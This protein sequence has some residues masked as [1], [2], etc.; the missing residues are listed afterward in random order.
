MVPGYFL[1]QPSIEWLQ[2]LSCPAGA[3]FYYMTPMGLFFTQLKLGL[4]YGLAF[5]SPVLAS[6]IWGFVAPAL[7][8]KE[9]IFMGVFSLCSCLLFFIG[10]CF[11][12]C[13]IFPLLMKFSYS[14][15]SA[16][17]APMLQ[18][19]SIIELAT[20]LMLGF[21]LMF[22]LPLIVI[23]LVYTDL[24]GIQRI[25]AAR[26][27]I[28]V[29]IFILSALLTPPDVVSQLCMGL[30]VWLLFELVLAVCRLLPKRLPD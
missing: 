19:D 3:Q 26:P 24:V 13:V 6:Q 4:V 8:R 27:Y 7:Y 30:P 2:R 15:G 12:V 20:M 5:S 18:V 23:F 11:A 14:M 10:V 22:Q 16:Q 21:G 9:K 28:V 17:I 25:R 1:A 29:L